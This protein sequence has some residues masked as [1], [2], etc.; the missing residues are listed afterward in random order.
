MARLA[1]LALLHVIYGVWLGALVTGAP[2]LERPLP[3]G[4]PLGNLLT[5]AALASLPAAASCLAPPHALARKFAALAFMLSLAWL[6]VSVLLAGNLA[7]HFGDD[8][9]DAWLAGSLGLVLLGW[10]AWCWSVVARLLARMGSAA[11]PTRSEP[12]P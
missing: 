3:G 9:G 11:A 4:L 7:L 1:A 12:L 2:W 5:A 6:P 10:L 8:V